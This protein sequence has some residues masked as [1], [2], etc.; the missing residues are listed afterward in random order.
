[1]LDRSINQS[2]YLLAKLIEV[3]NTVVF[4]L[5]NWRDHDYLEDD[6]DESEPI[7][8]DTADDPDH[9]QVTLREIDL[10][11]QQIEC[12]ECGDTDHIV[13]VGLGVSQSDDEDNEED[14]FDISTVGMVA[15]ACECIVYSACLTDKVVAILNATDEHA[16]ML[17]MLDKLNKCDEHGVLHA[18]E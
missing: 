16:L 12:P 7:A 9:T 11:D 15:Y 13:L 2:I 10:G 14:T 4:K 18:E 3:L 6:E 5:V 1:M 17:G 8:L